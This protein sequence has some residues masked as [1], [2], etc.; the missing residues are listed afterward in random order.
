VETA[1][2]PWTT[3]AFTQAAA[4]AAAGE[5]AFVDESRARVLTDRVRIA[6]ALRGLGF[7]PLPSST[8]FFL[9][10]VGDAAAT[11]RRMLARHRVL[12]RDCASFGLAGHVRVCARPP[13]DDDRL[14]T[15]FLEERGA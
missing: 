13:A 14:V 5:R 2:P 11:R 1:R 6:R 4:I 9:V 8:L 3:S 15:A 10:P 7:D 12:V